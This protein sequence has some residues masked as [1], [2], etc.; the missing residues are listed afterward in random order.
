VTL[1]AESLDAEY[2][3]VFQTVDGSDEL[4]L[5]AGEGWEAGAVGSVTVSPDS[6]FG[7]AMTPDYVV[8]F[9]NLREE[10]RSS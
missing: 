10:M 8:I 3:G 4:L 2:V 6:L 7:P 1:L 9:E 5:S